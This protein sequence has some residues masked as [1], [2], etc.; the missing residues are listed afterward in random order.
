MDLLQQTRWTESA[1]STTYLVQ[2]QDK[3]SVTPRGIG[4][5]NETTKK[6]EMRN[7]EHG[8]KKN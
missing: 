1:E 4:E 3:S 7:K 5:K 8:L 6:W 2:E